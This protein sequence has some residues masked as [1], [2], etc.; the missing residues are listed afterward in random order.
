MLICSDAYRTEK[1]NADRSSTLDSSAAPAVG[2]GAVSSIS[3]RLRFSRGTCPDLLACFHSVMNSTANSTANDKIWEE[4]R[5][6]A[7]PFDGLPGLAG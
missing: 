3:R 4:V 5:A 6:L 2:V 7:P 1:Q